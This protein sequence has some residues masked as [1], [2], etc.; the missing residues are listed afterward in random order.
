MAEAWRR[1]RGLRRGRL[2][3]GRRGGAQGRR[4]STGSISRTS[5]GSRCSRSIRAAKARARCAAERRLARARAPRPSRRRRRQRAGARRSRQRR[6]RPAGRFRRRRA[7]PMASASANSIRRRCTAL[8]KACDSTRRSA[9]NSISAPD[10]RSVRRPASPALVERSGAEPTTLD[11]AFGLDPIGAL[12]RSGRAPRAHGSDEARGARQGRG[13]PQGAGLRRPVRRR[14][15]ARASTPPAE[16]RRRSSPSRSRRRS[17]ICARSPTTASRSRTARGGDRLPPRRRRRPVRHPRQVPRPAPALGARRAGLRPDAAPA[18][19]H[20]ESAWRTMSARDP[21]VNV[22]RGATA[23]FSAGLGGADSV[24]VLPSHA[25]D[26]PARC[27]GAPA[28][29]QHAAHPAAKNRI[30]ASSPIPPPAP[31]CSRR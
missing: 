23:A 8:S 17:P 26:R 31:A 24:S 2:A 5:D 18:R 3:Q 6:R 4:P 11:V 20:A 28:G 15:R 27:A 7:A 22:M 25:G 16:R 12:A 9:S 1:V 14:R 13:L 30:S 19:V 10:G 21:Y 29:P